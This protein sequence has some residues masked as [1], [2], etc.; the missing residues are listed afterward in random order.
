MNKK[1]S[2]FAKINMLLIFIKLNGSKSHSTNFG[3][4]LTMYKIL[5]HPQRATSEPCR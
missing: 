2:T 4:D 3:A 5:K 1:Y